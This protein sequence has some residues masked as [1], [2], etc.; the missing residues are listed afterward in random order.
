MAAKLK[1]SL[2]NNPELS[3]GPGSYESKD[4]TFDG[5][6]KSYSMGVKMIKNFN[7]VVPGPGTYE[8]E[9]SDT[10]NSHGGVGNTSNAHYSFPKDPRVANK[11]AEKKADLPGP[12]TYSPKAPEK[13]GIT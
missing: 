6:S 11:D 13:N 5:R 8:I 4:H 12:N 9:K 2:A 7:K 1:N 3:P 10:V